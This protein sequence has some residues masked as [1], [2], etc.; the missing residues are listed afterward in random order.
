MWN[1]AP[2]GW[3]QWYHWL[4]QCWGISI[5]MDLET[6]GEMR[7][8]DTSSHDAMLEGIAK[9][10]L[11][12]TMAKHTKGPAS[13]YL[14]DLVVAIDGWRPDFVFCPMPIGC[15]NVM[16]MEAAVKDIC[17]EKNLPLC[18]MR[19]ELQD[20]RFISRQQMRDQVNKFMIDIMRAEPSN[21]DLLELDDY[22]PGKW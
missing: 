18:T 21:P 12:Q 9:R 13:N 22:G 20:N 7:H 6:I 15:K 14:S 1:P 4:E 10:Q 3:G 11:M 5:I 16:S 8:I 19:M 2:S 17:K